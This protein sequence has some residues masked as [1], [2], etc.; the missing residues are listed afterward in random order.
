MVEEHQCDYCKRMTWLSTGRLHVECLKATLC[1][2][3]KLIDVDIK[4]ETFCDSTCLQ[5]RIQEFS[6]TDEQMNKNGNKI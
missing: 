3:D 4:D 6:Y 5:S 2:F 1:H